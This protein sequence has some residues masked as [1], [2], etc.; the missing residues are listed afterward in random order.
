MAQPSRFNPRDAN[1]LVFVTGTAAGT[2]CTNYLARGVLDDHGPGLWQK[3]A[4]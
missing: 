2:G 4:L 1:G 3:F